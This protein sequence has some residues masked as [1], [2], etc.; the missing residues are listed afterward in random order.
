MW[1][2]FITS[3]CGRDGWWADCAPSGD[4]VVCCGLRTH[5]LLFHNYIVLGWVKWQ[6]VIQHVTVL[7]ISDQERS[8]IWEALT[9][10]V[11]SHLT[12][13]IWIHLLKLWSNSCFMYHPTCFAVNVFIMNCISTIITTSCLLDECEKEII[14]SC[15]MWSNILLTKIRSAR[16][17]HGLLSSLRT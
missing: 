17:K 11:E 14:F 7:Y 10:L 5:N 3:K 8:N 6:N 16:T 12:L 13:Y 4:R 1:R 15:R 9:N 2:K